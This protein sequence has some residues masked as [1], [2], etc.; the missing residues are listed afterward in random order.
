VVQTGK[1][2]G[3]VL[4]NDSLTTLVKAGKVESHEALSKGNDRT[5]LARKIGASPT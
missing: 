2:A 5:D 1:A 3:S 4:L